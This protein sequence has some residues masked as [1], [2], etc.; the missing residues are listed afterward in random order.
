[1]IIA[2][3]ARSDLCIVIILVKL[4]KF[5]VGCGVNDVPGF[6]AVQIVSRRG[7]ARKPGTSPQIVIRSVIGLCFCTP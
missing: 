1:M 7:Q 4:K 2:F 3:F 5:C 6:N